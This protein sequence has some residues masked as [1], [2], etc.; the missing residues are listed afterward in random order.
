MSDKQLDLVTG[1]TGIV[2]AHLIRELLQRGRR[3]RAVVRPTADREV[4]QRI[5]R[6]YGP[7]GEALFAR[8]EWVQGDL[9]DVFSL[10]EA[11][12]DV[13]RVFHSAALVSFDPRDQEALMRAN[14]SGTA[15]VVNMAMA[16][17]VRLLGH[18]S[19]T[20][21][22]GQHDPSGMLSEDT[23]WNADDAAS[24]YSISKYEAEL[25]VERGRA[26]GLDAVIVNPCIVLGP[27]AAGRSS[28]SLMERL[29]K[30]SRFHTTGSNAV[31]DARDV[32][33]ALVDLCEQGA[34][35]GRYL[36]IG[37][38]LGY[39]QLFE[40]ASAAFGRP[41]P[42]FAVRPWML[43][44]ASA[45]ESIRSFLFRRKALITRYTVASSLSS[46]KFSG[47]RAE[48][49]LGRRFRT[50]EEALANVAEYLRKERTVSDLP[51]RGGSAR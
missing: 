21:S 10:E 18:V 4:V 37:E 27:G 36:L 26:E 25:E 19:S 13:D 2:G 48:K 22:I 6:H 47:A 16:A 5:F 39:K 15:N 46:R 40:K 8:I 43:R 31:V 29:A 34:T 32:A 38:N 28:L 12:V 23:L 42:R 11:M 17:G 44:L 41:A 49:A 50:A 9:L 1:G 51:L 45:L 20:A 7:D 3:V 30:G 24:P 14:H 33:S 35:T